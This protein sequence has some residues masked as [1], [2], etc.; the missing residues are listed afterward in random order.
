MSQ[1]VHV[2]RASRSLKPEGLRVTLCPHRKGM[3]A[4]VEELDY[5]EI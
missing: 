1:D 3:M 4:R 5:G 2:R